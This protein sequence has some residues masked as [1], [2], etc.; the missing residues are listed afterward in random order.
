MDNPL[1]M[2]LCPLAFHVGEFRDEVS[3]H[4]SLHG[5]ARAVLYVEFA[6]LD[7]PQHHSSSGFKI[8]HCALECSACVVHRLLHL[9]FFSD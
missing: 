3:D 5:S 4:L 7:C 1:G 2:L 8:T 9:V 6:Q